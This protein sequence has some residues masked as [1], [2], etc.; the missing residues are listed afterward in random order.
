MGQVPGSTGCPAF[1]LRTGRGTEQVKENLY[2]LS[3]YV[4]KLGHRTRPMIMNS[5]RH[6]RQFQEELVQ[7]LNRFVDTQRERFPRDE[8]LRIYLHC[9]DLNSDKSTE[10][11]G[12]ILNS[13]RRG[14]PPGNSYKRWSTMVAMSLPSQTTTI[15]VPSGR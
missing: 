5:S 9:H 10:L 7:E 8:V 4:T 15:R 6:S 14:C 3:S 12:R 13:R 2:F 11:L 1:A